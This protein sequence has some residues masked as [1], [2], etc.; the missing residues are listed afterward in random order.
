M[1]I[2]AAKTFLEVVRT[3]SFV[4]AATALNLTQTAVS[5][6]SRVLEEQ[7]GDAVFIR[8]KTGTTLTRAGEQF[9][10]HA[11]MLV[12]TWENA[13]RAVALP[14]GSPMAVTVGVELSLCC[15]LYTSRCV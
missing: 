7:L 1:D 6:R 14:P 11:T 10:R 4:N 12:Q 13:R 15:L 3:G 8:A 2:A 9:R 5:A